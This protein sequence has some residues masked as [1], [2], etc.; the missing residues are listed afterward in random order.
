MEAAC[1]E[2]DQP[3][4]KSSYPQGAFSLWARRHQTNSAVC[5]QEN[6]LKRYLGEDF[7][8]ALLSYTR[9]ALV[10]KYLA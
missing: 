6:T 5:M 3:L 10:L 1:K 9:D 7:R 8:T 4:N 2:S